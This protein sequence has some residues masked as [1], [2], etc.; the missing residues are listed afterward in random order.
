MLDSNQKN[1]FE[2]FKRNGK[3]NVFIITGV[4][5]SKNYFNYELSKNKGNFDEVIVF[6]NRKS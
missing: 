6:F 5:G 2:K 3:N 1:I 4:A